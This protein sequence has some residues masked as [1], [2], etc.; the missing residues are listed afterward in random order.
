MKKKQ[1]RKE[2][3]DS[4]KH[5]GRRDFLLYGLQPEG[6]GYNIKVSEHT[7]YISAKES[8]DDKSIAI[9]TKDK[10]WFHDEVR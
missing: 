2:L 7:S 6:D 3:I 4:Y 8:M 1:L 10:V 9:V 5:E